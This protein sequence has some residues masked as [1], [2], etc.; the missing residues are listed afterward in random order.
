MMLALRKQLKNLHE[1]KARLTEHITK[2]SKD[3][4]A[5]LGDTKGIFISDH[6]ILRYLE[7]VKGYKIPNGSSD[8][9]KLNRLDVDL[10]AI[11]LEMLTLEEDRL[12]ISKQL[13]YYKKANHTYIIKNLSIVTVLLD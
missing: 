5:S 10:A 9:D 11:R 4:V 12:I 3:Y 6:S 13:Y 8:T 1:E 2:V 7:R